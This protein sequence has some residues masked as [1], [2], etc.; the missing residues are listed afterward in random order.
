MN[1]LYYCWVLVA[2]VEYHNSVKKCFINANYN[3][4]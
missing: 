3:F 2:Q 4:N 1:M